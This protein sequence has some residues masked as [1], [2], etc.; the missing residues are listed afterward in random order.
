MK[1]HTGRLIVGSV[2]SCMCNSYSS[3]RLICLP[4]KTFAGNADS[5]THLGANACF[6]LSLKTQSNCSFSRNILWASLPFCLCFSLSFLGFFCIVKT[7]LFFHGGMSLLLFFVFFGETLEQALI[8][9]IQHGAQGSRLMVLTLTI[10]GA[11]TS[12]QSQSNPAAIAG[13]IPAGRAPAGHYRKQV[14]SLAHRPL[15]SRVENPAPVCSD[16]GRWEQAFG[17]PITLE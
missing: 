14:Q 5:N 1:G 2:C 17:M 12:H 13:E 6:V 10:P 15:H 16:G 3:V 11:S 9:K 7:C 8:G 4:P